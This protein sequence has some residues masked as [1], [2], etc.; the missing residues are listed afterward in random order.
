[1]N[2]INS[3]NYVILRAK[4]NKKIKFKSKMRKKI[5]FLR[6]K[7]DLLEKNGDICR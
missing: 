4:V 2:L 1:M 5:T 7:V 6:K 3:G